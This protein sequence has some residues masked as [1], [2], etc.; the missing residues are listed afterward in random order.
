MLLLVVKEAG[1][2]GQIVAGGSFLND[3]ANE[4]S[5]EASASPQAEKRRHHRWELL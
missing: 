5:F 2:D 3:L 1:G 4:Y